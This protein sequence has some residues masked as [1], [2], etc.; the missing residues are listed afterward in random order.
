M[1]TDS[2][3]GTTESIVLVS[4]D[5]DLEPAVS[6]IKKNTA[7]KVSV[8]IPVLEN[9]R[10]QRRNDYYES[11]GVTCRNLPIDDILKHQLSPRVA[12]ASGKIIERPAT[13]V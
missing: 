10:K 8:Y 5:S 3:S 12:L 1:V 2:F 7:V 11:I 6:W 9:E 4:G 13:W